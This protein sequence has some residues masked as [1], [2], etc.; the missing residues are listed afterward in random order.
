MGSHVSQDGELDIEL[1]HRIQCGW[2]SWCKLTGI[3][4]DRRVS[5][6]L[7]GKI[8]K[9]AVRPA[10]LYGSETWAVKK[11]QEKKM[12]IAEMRM[13]R[14]MCGVTRRDRIRN[15]HIRGTVKVAELSSKM[16]ERRLNWY[17]HIMRGNGVGSTRREGQGKT[18]I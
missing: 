10:M 4:C 12:N 11:T 8:Y 14:W 7:K 18:K 17:G 1:R 13:L 3:L 15:E 6:R 2:N 16:Q 9:T 5:V